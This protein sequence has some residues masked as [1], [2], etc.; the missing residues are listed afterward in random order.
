MV[1]MDSGGSTFVVYPNPTASF[2]RVVAAAASTRVEVDKVDLVTL[3][4]PGDW[5]Q[6]DVNANSSHVIITSQPALATV[7]LSAVN[8]YPCM[9]EL[10][11]E[12]KWLSV[13]TS[14]VAFASTGNVQGLLFIGLPNSYTSFFPQTFFRA[15]SY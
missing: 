14:Y 7:T 6:V 4:R 5:V 10:V 15:Y 3:T 11:P 8:A 2:V 13:Y 12:E 1:G 9:T